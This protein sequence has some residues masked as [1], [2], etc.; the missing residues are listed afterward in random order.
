[1]SSSSSKSETTVG[2]ATLKAPTRDGTVTL[3]YPLLTKSNYSAWAL[4]MKV[5]MHA[6]GVWDAIEPIDLNEGVET[7]KD[8]MDL[9]AI[10]QGISE[11]TLLVL[12]EKE[13]AK[14]AWEMLK[15]MHM[16]A[17]LIK[18]AKIHT[19]R[20]EFEGLRMREAET[21]DGFATKLTT[22]V[23]KIRALGD[24]VKEAYVIKKLLHAVPSKFIQIASTIEQ[25]GNLQ[26]MTV[27][28]VIGSLKAHEERLRGYED[29]KE[30]H[31]LLTK[32]EWKAREEGEGT[33]NLL[34]GRGGNNWRGRGRGLGHSDDRSGNEGTH[35]EKKFDKTKVKYYN[36]HYFGH[37]AYECRSK[38]K[39]EE[40]YLVEKQ[41]DN[42]D[43]PTLLM[44][45]HLVEK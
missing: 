39:D 4:K 34:R 44:T 30:E 8:Q 41:D 10:Y 12:A 7:W 21:V 24:K 11:E 22:I 25:F 16:G 26:T 27:E 23:N 40:A 13:T 35:Q 1:M 17:E 2:T 43:E 28:E 38:K 15:T 18:E 29:E 42:D 9:A 33:S 45:T 36:C 31:I 20:S 14:E 19:L 5:Y 32:A 37:Y 3:Q 6:K